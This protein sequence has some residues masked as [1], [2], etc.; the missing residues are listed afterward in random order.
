MSRTPSTPSTAGT[1]PLPV[2]RGNKVRFVHEARPNATFQK[3]DILIITDCNH[4]FY[5]A[6]RKD[7]AKGLFYRY[8]LEVA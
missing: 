1:D 2:K 6:K 7:G 4:P 5:W 3:G 8:E